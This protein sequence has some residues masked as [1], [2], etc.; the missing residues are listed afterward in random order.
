MPIADLSHAKMHS[1]KRVGFWASDE[2]RDLPHPRDF[3]DP[4]WSASEKDQ[5]LSYL[6][7]AYHT[8]YMYCG[9]SWC[10]LGCEGTPEDIGTQDR[11]DGTWIFPEGLAHYI[12]AHAVRPPEEFLDHLRA[13][14]FQLPKLSV[15]DLDQWQ[16]AREARIAARSNSRP[17]R[18]CS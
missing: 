10:R 12:Q 11:T 18:R 8:A 7:D 1:L 3:V 16:T 2:Q 9:Y 5:L 6:S 14:C 4:S 15:V 13:N 17:T